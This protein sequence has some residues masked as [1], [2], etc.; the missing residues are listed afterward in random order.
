MASQSASHRA[1][2]EV[3]PCPDDEFSVEEWQSFWFF[4]AAEDT[5]K[6]PCLAMRIHELTK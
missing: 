3:V 6:G 2:P 4:H 1:L 5:E